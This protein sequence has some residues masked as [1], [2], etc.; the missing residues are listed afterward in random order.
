MTADDRMTVG[1]H[2]ESPK[3]LAA[4]FLR[5]LLAAGPDLLADGPHRATEVYGRLAETTASPKGR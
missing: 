5:D 1:E 2:A 4:R 3:R